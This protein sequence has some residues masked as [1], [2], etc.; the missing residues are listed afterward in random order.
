MGGMGLFTFRRQQQDPPA[1]PPPGSQKAPESPAPAQPPTSRTVLRQAELDI[2]LEDLQAGAACQRALLPPGPPAVPGYDF[3]VWC[4]PARAL[5]GDFHDFLPFQ[6][7]R[8]PIVVADASG[9]GVP[10]ALMAAIGQ[11]LF[12]VQPEPSASPARVLSIVNQMISG[13]I[14]RGTFISG[15]Y[16]VLD[17]AQHV[18][19]LANAGHLPAVI[20]HSREKVAT[21]HRT[22]GAVLGVLP[23]EA[24]DAEIKEESLALKPGDRFLL[25]TDGMNEAM[26]PGQKEFGME[27]LRLRLKNESDG[28]SA[29]FLRSLTEQIEMHRG[30]GEQSDDITLITARRIP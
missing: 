18:L 21:T 2:I 28:P 26:A 30:G 9:K 27:H 3:G 19:H 17:T 10:A 25:F 22:S 4:R 6:G 15:I 5:S 8:L 13:N 23:S 20:W 29:D 11:V 14:K 16:A 12:R 1:T 7:S 24:Y